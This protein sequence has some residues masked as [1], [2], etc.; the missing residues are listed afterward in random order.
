M[1]TAPF[2]S[3]HEIE[4]RGGEI[5]ANSHMIVE[6]ICKYDHANLYLIICSEFFFDLGIHINF[7]S[8]HLV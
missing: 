3:L 6:V 1:G 2:K 7:K 8:V 4:F 5:M